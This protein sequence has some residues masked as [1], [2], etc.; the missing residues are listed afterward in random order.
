M[1]LYRDGF[2]SAQEGAKRLLQ[3]HHEIGD[4]EE[5]V[6]PDEDFVSCY[7]CGQI[8][9]IGIEYRAICERWSYDWA[10]IICTNSLSPLPKMA[11]AVDIPE[12]ENF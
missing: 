10:K 7:C 8:R 12:N 11:Q 3:L 6:C 2:N 1:K 4:L 9:E 5:H